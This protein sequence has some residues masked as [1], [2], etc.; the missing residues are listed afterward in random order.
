M[1]ASSLFTEVRLVPVV[2]LVEPI[3]AVPLAR[4][5][6]SAGIK[7]IEVTLRTAGALSAIESIAR[8]VPDILL[9]AGSVRHAGQ[10]QQIKDAGCAFAVSPGST[11][12]LLDAANMPY[13]PGAA[14]A[15]E[16]LHL[17]ERNY[18]LIKFFPA[19]VNGG[20]T[21]LKAISQPV[22]EVRFCPT[23]GINATLAPQYLQLEAVSCVGGSWFI[24]ADQLNAGNFVAIKASAE[25]AVSLCY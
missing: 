9:G 15:S 20:I 19:E 18:Q 2:T 1:D 21:A 11:E 22:P 10:F 6:L 3:H 16:V 17:L 23:G 12:S 5:L 25:A 7:A 14:T 13:L 24:S 4:T 8:E